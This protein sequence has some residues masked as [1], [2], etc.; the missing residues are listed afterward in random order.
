MCLR[1]TDDHLLYGR[2]LFDRNFARKVAAVDEDRLRPFCDSCQ[3]TQSTEALYLRY[4][5]RVAA[6]MGADDIHVGGTMGEGKRKV[7]NA[8]SPADGNRG[9]VLLR[10]R[11]HLDGTLD[12]H[13]LVLPDLSAVQ[14]PK[15]NL[16]VAFFNNL[17]QDRVEI[18]ADEVADFE[19]ADDVC[20]VEAD[21][22]LVTR[23]GPSMRRQKPIFSHDHLAIGKWPCADLGA[24]CV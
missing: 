19:L 10:E 20:R 14:D 8:H 3:M 12:R 18:D 2:D 16:F 13:R 11:R 6:G 4:D 15:E 23:D 9:D 5:R 17:G 21:G 22:G 1:L 7:A 24:F